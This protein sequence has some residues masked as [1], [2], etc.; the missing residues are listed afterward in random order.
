MDAARWWANPARSATS[1]KEIQHLASDLMQWGMSKEAARFEAEQMVQASVL[2]D[3]VKLWPQ[4]LRVYQLFAAC[5][6]QWRWLVM[7]MRAVRTGLDY[8]ALP[9]VLG[10]KRIDQKFFD[11]LRIMELA[12]LEVL[13][14][15]H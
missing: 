2:N 9:A 12:A 15:E 5:G 4:H 6:T 10:A 8:A 7:P 1:E 11:D 3:D 13:N 14:G